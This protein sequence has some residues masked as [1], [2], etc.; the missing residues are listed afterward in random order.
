ML[1]KVSLVLNPATPHPELNHYIWSAGE[2]LIEDIVMHQVGRTREGSRL[3]VGN[4]GESELY[5]K[6][7]AAGDC[8]YWRC[9]NS[10][11]GPFQ[12][13]WWHTKYDEAECGCNINIVV[14]WLRGSY[15]GL[16]GKGGGLLMTAGQGRESVR[17]LR[18][19]KEFRW[20]RD[21][22]SESLFLAI[23]WTGL[24]VW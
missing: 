13:I 23:A 10:R 8:G 11:P 5:L 7:L 3:E 18:R 2:I 16:L 19:N 22:S 4:L 21:R 17:G 14:A 9:H 15:D 24:K 20:E 1:T 12:I 6:D